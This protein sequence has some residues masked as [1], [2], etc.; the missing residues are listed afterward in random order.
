MKT[1]RQEFL[2]SILKKGESYAGIILGKGGDPDYHLILLAPEEV[3][4]NW[5]TA[6]EFAAKVGGEL[7]TSREQYLLVANL[8]EEFPENYY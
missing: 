2:A 3:Y 4:A 8:K 7:P 5:K 1:A 6:E